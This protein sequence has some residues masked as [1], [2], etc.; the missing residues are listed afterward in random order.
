MIV[1]NL[2]KARLGV[3]CVMTQ[4]YR[5]GLESWD[6]IG[7]EKVFVNWVWDWVSKCILGFSF[8][9]QNHADGL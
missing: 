2:G 5:Q 7:S 6:G 3:C 1:G 9:V 8:Q 4:I